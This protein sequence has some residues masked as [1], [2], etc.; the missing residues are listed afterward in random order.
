MKKI[1]FFIALLAAKAAQGL[2]KLLGRNATYLPG[3]IATKLCK[4][5]LRHLTPP[6]TV[7]AVTG[8]NGKRQVRALPP[9]CQP[10][11]LFLLLPLRILP[12]RQLS[13]PFSS[14]S[15]VFKLF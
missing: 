9:F 6:K 3:K 13:V 14:S 8:T 4:D 2:M 7:I 12:F 10:L 1:Q 5:F 11:L 15:C